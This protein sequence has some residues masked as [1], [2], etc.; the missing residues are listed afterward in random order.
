MTHDDVYDSDWYREHVAKAERGNR[1]HV[2]RFERS[3]TGIMAKADDDGDHDAGDRNAGGGGLANHPVVQLATLLIGSGKFANYGDAFHH[4]L[5]TSQGAALLHRTRKAEKEEPMDTVYSIMKSSGIGAT[6]AAIVAKGSTSLTELEIVEAATLVA[7]KRHPELLPAQ[8][9]DRVYSDPEEGRVLQHALKIAKAAEFAVFDIK[10]V[11]VGGEDAQDVDNAT[12]AMR[13]YEE[14]LRIAREKFPFL[15]ADQAF[16]R[17]LEDK[18]YAA[19]AEQALSRPQPTTIY[20]MP[21]ST[22]PGRGAYTKSDPAPNAD[23]AYGELMRK[24]EEYR[25]AHPGLSIAQCFDK[26][27]TDRANVELAKRERLESAPR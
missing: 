6:C 14:I 8:A 21:G 19:L 10:P 9:F 1:E 23:T 20:A 2:A 15:P 17:T 5:N 11:A 7:S 13:A 26:I 4:L 24:A 27:Y 22:A 3:F 18:N 25:S 12:A 16:V